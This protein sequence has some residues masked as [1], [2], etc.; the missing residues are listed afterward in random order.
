MEA[1]DRLCVRVSGWDE[2]IAMVMVVLTIDVAGEMRI[3]MLQ[4]HLVRENV[5]DDDDTV[6]VIPA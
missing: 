1:S 5:V 3:W 2:E 4:T 6:R